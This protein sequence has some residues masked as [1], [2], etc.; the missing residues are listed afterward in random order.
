MKEEKKIAYYLEEAKLKNEK[1]REFEVDE[2]VLICH[3]NCPVCEEDF[4]IGEKII[5]F[6]IQEPKT[7]P[8]HSKCYRNEYR[9]GPRI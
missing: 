1:M 2:S 5:F 9:G 7:I 6:P 3:S 4:K 8:V